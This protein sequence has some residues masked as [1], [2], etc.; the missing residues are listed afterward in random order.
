[1]EKLASQLN[2]LHEI[3]ETATDDSW[4]KDVQQIL[5]DVC[6][7]ALQNIGIPYP[8][9]KQIVFIDSSIDTKGGHWGTNNTIYI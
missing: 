2:Q 7:D 3:L 4:I 8:K 9:H 1:M 6:K 5:N